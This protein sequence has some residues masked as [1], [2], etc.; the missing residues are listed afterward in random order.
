MA[1]GYKLH[2]VKVRESHSFSR[3]KRIL[4]ITNASHIWINDM[5]DVK[6]IDTDNDVFLDA[7][8]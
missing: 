3:S 7:G 8:Q 5:L 2:Y 4:L 6:D 1:A